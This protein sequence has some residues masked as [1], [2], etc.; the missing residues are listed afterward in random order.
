MINRKA[1]SEALL[2]GRRST[3]FIEGITLIDDL[4]WKDNLKKWI[5]HCSLYSDK[6]DA[7]IIPKRT[8]WYILIDDQYPR[9][10]IGFYPSKKNSLNQTFRH[11]MF[12]GEGNNDFPWRTGLLCLDTNVR[13]LGRLVPNDEPFEEETRLAWY[14]LRAIEWLIAASRNMLTLED[15]PFELMDFPESS[16]LSLG[17]SENY[18]SYRFWNFIDS[19]HGI[20]EFSIVSQG[21]FLV[22]SFKKLNGSCI[23]NVKWGEYAS[24][25]RTEERL[26]GSWILLEDVPHL[27]PWQAPLTWSELYTVCKEQGLDLIETLRLLAKKR[28]YKNKLAHILLI[29]FPVKSKLNDDNS[30]IFWKGI[31]IPLLVSENSFSKKV[32]WKINGSAKS[33]NGFTVNGQRKIKW[34]HSYNW[35]K[36]SVMSRGILP[37][38]ITESQILQIGAGSLGSSIGELLT[39]AGV[40]K[41]GIID[42]DF[43][44]MG[45]LTRHNL[46][47]SDLDNNKAQ[48]LTNKLNR[49]SIY[50]KVAPFKGT[51]KENLEHRIEDLE[52]YNVILDCTGDDD[53][54]VELEQFK[55]SRLK[56]IISLSLG[57]GGRRLFIFS[58]SGTTF[59]N[60]V[61][62][63]M[64]NPWLRDEQDKYKDEELPREGLGCW[65]PLFPARID[66]VW[67][68]A[69]TAIKTFEVIFKENSTTP[70]LFVYEQ[71]WNNG[72]FEGIR[73]VFEE[74]YNG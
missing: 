5:I 55:W 43:L 64:I 1:P 28:D 73:L 32:K 52:K 69:S 57:F 62:K 66:D 7:T 18:Q 39:R 11:Q 67:L 4:E 23:R 20:C 27:K 21:T 16:P 35:S 74:E 12:N 44:Q 63:T 59:P 33:P 49:T 31:E 3:E 30:E 37:K 8:D 51:L 68:M 48:A 46:L 72:A 25:F 14:I 10:N 45:N 15:E 24:Q 70:K 26:L 40:S 65:H 22:R 13:A 60:Q 58:S 50:S 9:G 17:F 41:L 56:K 47:I 42:F 19:K 71:Q 29:G 53:V 2:K 54:L 6:I 61:F 34:M 36:E 38:K